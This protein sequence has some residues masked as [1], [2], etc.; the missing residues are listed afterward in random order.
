MKETRF[1]HLIMQCGNPCP[2]GEE[3]R[4]MNMKAQVYMKE[5]GFEYER[6]EP[7]SFQECWHFYDVTGGPD[8]LPEFFTEA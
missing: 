2:K 4:A 7:N 5:I 1:K 8:V 6:C 3:L